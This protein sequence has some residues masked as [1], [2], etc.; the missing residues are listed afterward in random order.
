MIVAGKWWSAGT[1]LLAACLTAGALP[2]QAQLPHDASWTFEGSQGGYCIWYLADPDIARKMVPSSTVLTPAGTGADL[3]VL[4][5]ST[6]REEPRFAQW[7]PG[8]ICLGFYQRISAGDHT[9]AEAKEDRPLIVATSSL[10]A[11]N[12]HGAEGA[13]RYLLSFMTNNHDVSDA[14]D[15]LGVSMD[16]LDY[17][18]RLRLEGG[19]P[20]VTIK[21][22]GIVISWSGHAIADSSVG[23]TRSMSFGYGGPKSVPW[24]LRLETTP[25]SS[26]SIV[27]NLSISGRNDLAKALLASPVRAMGPE[28]SGGSSTLTFHAATRH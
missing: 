12:A 2:G 28:E 7:I 6:I 26:R 5:A 8:V 22:A 18:S 25:A 9:V 23:T 11:E 27:G 1:G 14:A 13:T 3:P 10:A 16:D 20:S 21:L 17:L 15:R 4:L 24:L 19:D